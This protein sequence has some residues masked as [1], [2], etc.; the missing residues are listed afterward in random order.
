MWYSSFLQVKDMLT[1]VQKYHD[2]QYRNTPD[3][4]YWIHCIQVGHLLYHALE[5]NND[6]DNKRKQE[7]MICAAIG[8]D[9]L[10][11]TKI[12]KEELLSRFN[13][14]VVHWIQEMTNE[15]GDY[16]RE[17]Y[18]QKLHS[19]SE[20]ALL[21]KYCDFIENTLSVQYSLDILSK[22]WL[23]NFYIPIKED[24]FQLLNVYQKTWVYF[25][26]TANYLQSMSQYVNNNFNMLVNIYHSI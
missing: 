7:D 24:T 26:K 22:E 17:K 12:S 3:N 19:G 1:C 25:P 21:I 4:P 8:H 11:D 15:D 6:I 13:D 5:K 14:S 2:G 9:L 16:N 23:E 20:E 18:I 10:E